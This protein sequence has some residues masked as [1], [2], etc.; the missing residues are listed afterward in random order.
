[1]SILTAKDAATALGYTG[2]S[3]SQWFVVYGHQLFVKKLVN[4]DCTG[5]VIRKYSVH[6]R[7]DAGR[8]IADCPICSRSNYVDPD[9]PVFFC[10]GCGNQGSGS[11]VPVIF[12][13]TDVR[14]QIE[15]L[16]L[17]R[18]V[19]SDV[20]DKNSISQALNS[21][22]KYPGLARNWSEQTIAELEQANKVMEA[23]DD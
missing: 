10:F 4:F 18:P 20:E 9:E 14:G 21:K 17:A 2:M 19:Y 7:I 12:P 16:L 22:P 8:W 5:N 6:A 11:F 1:M 15:N 13:D 23:E 3:A